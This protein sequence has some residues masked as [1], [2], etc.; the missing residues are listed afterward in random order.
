MLSLNTFIIIISQ[1]LALAFIKLSTVTGLKVLSSPDQSGKFHVVKLASFPEH[2]IR[3]KS[4]KGVCDSG[5]RQFSGYLDIAGSKHLFF[6]LFESKNQP[7]SDPLVM[8]LNGGPGCSSQLGALMELGPCRI[9]EDGEGAQPNPD[10]WNRNSNLLFLDQPTGVGYSYQETSEKLVRNSNEAAVDVYAFLQLLYSHFPEYKNLEFTVAG[11]SYAG[12]Y[13]PNIALRIIKENQA[14]A[15]APLSKNIPVPLKTVMIGNGMTDPLT[16]FTSAADYGCPP[17]PYAVLDKSACEA[18]RE[19][20]QVCRDLTQK[21][22]NDISPHNCAPAT[23]YCFNYVAK[24]IRP[25]GLNQYD[26]RQRCPSGGLCYPEPGWIQSYLNKPDVKHDLGVKPERT[27]LACNSDVQSAFLSAGDASHNA[28]ILV[29]KIVSSGVR[30]L[31]YVGE[32][33]YICNYVGNERWMLN[34]ETPFS[35]QFRMRAQRYLSTIPLNNQTLIPRQEVPGQVGTIRVGG[36]GAGN[37]VLI[38]LFAAGHLV[39]TDQPKIALELFEK[40]IKNDVLV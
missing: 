35:K 31:A 8:W 13:I 24:A 17:S 23:D 25:T 20:A 16:Q 28:A 40:W 7:K 29:P 10:S 6:Y 9:Q 3:V 18:L 38:T 33:D 2:E 4:P 5:A 11:E 1:A 36:K 12:A 34:L 32:E 26:I 37:L 22:Y 27:Y 30:F 15:R 19:D 21:C 39:P 14:L